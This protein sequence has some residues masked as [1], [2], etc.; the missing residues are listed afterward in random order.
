MLRAIVR[1]RRICIRARPNP[2]GVPRPQPASSATQRLPKIL[3]SVES[4]T[5]D[6][7]RWPLFERPLG[8][9]PIHR[10]V[11]VPRPIA[12]WARSTGAMLPC[13]NCLSASGSSARWRASEFAARRGR[14]VSRTGA[15]DENGG[16]GQRRSPDGNRPAEALSPHWPGAGHGDATV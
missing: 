11:A 2:D 9:D 8:I 16:G 7:R 13:W 5:M 4:E 12:T 1:N 14:R 6:F 3:E 10:R 15:A